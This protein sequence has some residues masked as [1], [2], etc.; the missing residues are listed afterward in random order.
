MPHTP[1]RLTTWQQFVDADCTNL[2]WMLRIGKH[3]PRLIVELPRPQPNRNLS[4]L[5]VHH[6]HLQQILVRNIRNI[7]N[8]RLTP[9][10]CCTLGFDMNFD[11]IPTA[12]EISGLVAVDKYVKQPIAC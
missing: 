3:N 2:S 10:Q 1:P 11:N 12:A 4:T 8:I 9:V 7:R 5:T 6:V